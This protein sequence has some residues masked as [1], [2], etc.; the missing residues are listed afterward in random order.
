MPLVVSFLEILRIEDR[1]PQAAFIS[2]LAFVGAAI[3]GNGWLTGSL[4]G[5]ISMGFL[6]QEMKAGLDWA[7]FSVSQIVPW[8]ITTV[9]LLTYIF[10]VFRPGSFEDTS[11]HI[12]KEY[13][14]IKAFSTLE[15]VT[16]IVLVLCFLAFVTTPWHHFPSAAICLIGLFALYVFQVMDIKDIAIGINWDVILFIGAAL[17]IAPIFKV[18]GVGDWLGQLV[19]PIVEPI[20]GSP[21]TFVLVITLISFL[22]RFIDAAFGLPT[23]ALIL[24]LT[25]LFSKFGI[26]PLVLCTVAGAAQM[27]FFLSYQSSF[28]FI[29]NSITQNRG[30]SEKQLMIG[31]VG[32]VIAVLISMTISVFYW[33]AL[34][35][36]K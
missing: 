13:Q 20:A 18:S 23:A 25:P 14:S 10:I 2:L 35:L 22:M 8:T 1:S 11:E 32:Y 29:A 17:S 34:G 3:P 26:H 30:W 6:P 9:I 7:S 4:A 24:A 33:Q 21:I 16:L 12:N 27:F 19:Y 31:G 28:A 36:I 5:P 15:L